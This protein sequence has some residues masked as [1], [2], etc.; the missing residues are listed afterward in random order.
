MKYTVLVD[1]YNPDLAS[2]VILRNSELLD[3]YY[4]SNSNISTVG[5]IYIG[6]V[7]NIIKSLSAYFIDYGVDKNGFLPFTS[8]IGEFK[9]DDLIIVQVLKNE[10]D[11]KGA[12]LSCFVKIIGQYSILLPYGAVRNKNDEIS[13][14]SVITKP[15][16]SNIN[17]QS[18]KKD[19]D[20]LMTLWQNMLT[21]SRSASS[22]GI[23]YQEDSLIQRILRDKYQGSA[24]EIIVDGHE[25]FKKIQKTVQDLSLPHH[26]K[27]HRSLI[28]IFLRFGIAHDIRN[29]KNR[30]IDL[31]SGGSAI[32]D[33]SEAMISID[34]NSSP[35]TLR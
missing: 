27:E 32:I 9:K 26:V 1:A 7:I 12:R 5:N 34:I 35:C 29:L 18:I 20:S 25:E 23:L 19:L 11:N 31:P 3:I 22:P 16:L 14:H 13:S 17:Y 21:M 2:I 8:A 4:E 6:K 33:V 28:P 24:I 15:G 30:S 10:K